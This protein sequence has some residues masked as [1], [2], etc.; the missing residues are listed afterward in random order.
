[1]DPI[2]LQLLQQA[3]ASAG[4]PGMYAPAVGGGAS[5]LAQLAD[6][7]QPAV[8]GTTYPNLAPL[9]GLQLEQYGPIGGLIGAVG[10]QAMFSVLAQQGMLARG[11][12]GSY[13]QAYQTREFFKSRRQLAAAVSQQDAE[14]IYRTLRGAAALAGMPFDA[15]QREA[16]RS[17]SST[18]ADLLPS[19]AQFSPQAADAIYDAVSG[20]RGSVQS[21]AL[22]MLEAN[23][24]RIDPTTGRIGFSVAANQQLAEDVFKVMFADDNIA[25][26]QG[27]RASDIGR[28]YKELSTEGLV[29]AAPGNIRERTIQALLASEVEGLDLTQAAKD[30]GVTL[31]PGTNLESLSNAELMKL[32]E[33]SAVKTKL[34]QSEV[35]QITDQLQGYVDALAAM[36]EV[37]GENGNPN[38]P[39]PKLIGMLKGLTSGQMQKF[40]PAQLNTIVRDMQAMSQ[41]SGKSV[42][43]IVAMTQ[44]AN[45]INAQIL[46]DQYGVHFN[47]E[48]T[49]IGM[50]TGMAFSEVGGATGFGALN[51]E[52]TEQA[53]MSLY[54]RGM[55]SQLANTVG[56]LARIE[57]AG[58]FSGTDAGRALS[59]A[60][61]ALKAG[62]ETYTYT[63]DDGTTVS[64]KTPMY[65]YEFMALASQGAINNMGTGDFGLMLTD[66]TANLRILGENPE[67]SKIPFTMQFAE[68]NTKISKNLTSLLAG[69]PAFSGK[70][71]AAA[72]LAERITKVADELSPRDIQDSATRQRLIEADVRATNKVLDLEL[73]DEVI[74]SLVE[75]AL[76]RRE[77]VIFKNTGLDQSSWQQTNSRLVRESRNTQEAAVSARAAMNAAMSGLGRPGSITQKFFEALQAQGASGAAADIPSLLADTFGIGPDLNT[78]E[79]E[80][81]VQA[82]KESFDKVNELTAEL[83]GANPE[84]RAEIA[85][86]IKIETSKL[87]ASVAAFRKLSE[88]YGL[89]PDENRFNLEDQAKAKQAVRET[90]F[91]LEENL[92]KK[93]VLVTNVTDADLAAN[94]DL[95]L[96]VQDIEMVRRALYEQSLKAAEAQAETAI[97]TGNFQGLPE[98]AEQ[99]FK[100][101][102]NELN[103]EVA[104]SRFIEY[105][106]NQVGAMRKL[107]IN[108]QLL[109]DIK[110]PE[111]QR[112]VLQ[113]RRARATNLSV[114]PGDIKARVDELR[115][116]PEGQQVK[117]KEELDQLSLEDKK[118]YTEKE[119]ELNLRAESELIAERFARSLGLFTSENKLTEDPS[120]FVNL[121]QAQQTEL[122]KAA[123]AD[124]GSLLRK[125]AIQASIEK[126]SGPL[127]ESQ[128]R[129]V[130]A[131]ISGTENTASDLSK[132]FEVISS[133]LSQY[134]QDPLALIVGGAT[135]NANYNSA[136]KAVSALQELAKD[137]Y[138]N[139]IGRMLLDSGANIPEESLQSILDKLE[140]PRKDEIRQALG[141]KPNADITP[142]NLR[143]YIKTAVDTSTGQLYST[144]T[145]L[146]AGSRESILAAA[147]PDAISRAIAITDSNLTNEE[148]SIITQNLNTPELPQ[149]ISPE[150]KKV[151]ELAKNLQALDT[152]NIGT[153]EDLASL[154]QQEKNIRDTAAGLKLSDEDLN[155]FIED[156]SLPT[157]WEIFEGSKGA[158][159]ANEL[160]QRLNQARSNAN[161][162]KGDNQEIE[163][164]KVAAFETELQAMFDNKLDVAQI[165]SLLGKQDQ[166]TALRISQAR[167]SEQSKATI[168]SLPEEARENISALK[169]SA[170]GVAQEADA[171]AARR[172]EAR[173]EAELKANFEDIFG[174]KSPADEITKYKELKASDIGG[175]NI[176]FL[177]SLIKKIP[178][179][180]TASGSGIQKLDQLRTDWTSAN[181]EG[182]K[183]LARQWGQTPEAVEK[184]IQNFEHFNLDGK[185]K[186]SDILNTLKSVDI[187]KQAQDEAAK[188]MNLVGSVEITGEV[189]QGTAAFNNVTGSLMTG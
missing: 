21:L 152:L 89:L 172:E 39:V 147:G 91:L 3:A 12:A 94:K 148:L 28:L 8:A 30:Q 81:K 162:S 119:R 168:E 116:T 139:D 47:P 15:D 86:E 44:T 129:A 72:I 87:N 103:P 37:F 150:V 22:Q 51:R 43:Q 23:R 158:N 14:G 98:D 68:V 74:S 4:M 45:A 84:K 32:R 106:R 102:Q 123:P 69:N 121:T 132:N 6:A 143:K 183:S 134:S 184:L 1:M 2:Q 187:Q 52:Q 164:Q 88:D 49:K 59:A 117:S 126:L 57:R 159:K 48:A 25:K 50:T 80:S 140:E 185:T 122:S 10:G 166:V 100:D 180:Y 157:G 156:G 101:L 149:G 77:E 128:R 41:L 16:A 173:L 35:R 54:G 136:F 55:G 145:S 7:Y 62:S 53:A 63:R 171:A 33:N 71:G 65:E 46:G 127:D 42:D 112:S 160:V 125:F 170:A 17:L 34:N 29:G 90:E 38:A 31:A 92:I 67:L 24:Y 18:I 115:G 120:K 85:N 176:E 177:D 153:V 142:E 70:P 104:K 61:S 26:M 167:F 9:A 182:K 181:D 60:F 66:R 169:T 161:R 58:G 144:V 19:I 155:K 151:L 137:Y 78:Q 174:T 108:A 179:S 11:N 130:D 165:T 5:M 118:A 175:R 131:Q 56:A 82:I 13:M 79:L 27:L 138:N 124:R 96:Q 73:N 188:T 99:K 110:D 189:I 111:I 178:A 141:L 40:E 135:G 64:G 113:S 76:G 154:D 105:M 36:R 20:P 75:L 95:K 146:Q 133:V 163:N 83:Q 97:D 107:A 93:A 186:F 114:L 109:G